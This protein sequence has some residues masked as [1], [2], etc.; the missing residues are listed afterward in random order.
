MTV[1]PARPTAAA[2]VAH[3]AVRATTPRPA[4]PGWQA[5]PS[6]YRALDVALALGLLVVAA[7]LLA[8]AAV[9]IRLDSPGPVIFRQKIGRAHV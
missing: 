6:A 1:S 7:P 3:P 9:S 2:A 5:C 8:V 4:P